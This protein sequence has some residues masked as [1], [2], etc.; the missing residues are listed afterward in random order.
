VQSIVA[1]AIEF[2]GGQKALARDI[3][4]VR[5]EESVMIFDGDKIPVKSTWR[6]QPPDSRA[7]HAVVQM[8]ELRLNMHQA[9]S[10]KTGWAKFGPS[11]T[12]IELRT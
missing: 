10:G 1:K 3:P 8:G 11:G 2:Y 5:T 6:Y 4:L 12:E 7:F 9:I